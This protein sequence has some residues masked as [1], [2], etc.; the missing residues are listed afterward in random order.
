MLTVTSPTG[1]TTLPSTGFQV[2]GTC[3]VNHRVTVRLTMTS[4]GQ[5]HDYS[6]QALQGGWF[7]TV[8]PWGAGPY[9]ITV[10]CEGLTD[11][12]T[13]SFSVGSP[14]GPPGGP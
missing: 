14:A 12:I 11:A 4:T 2:S 8:Y 7:T 10:T 13:V 5:F 3:N 9:K 1:G 6:A